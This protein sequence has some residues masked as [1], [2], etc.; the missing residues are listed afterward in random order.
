MRP[1]RLTMQAFGPY[2]GQE[3]VDFRTLGDRRFFLI[4]GPT[5]SGKTTVL[6]AICYALYGKSSGAE[7]DVREM[8]SHHSPDDLPT[9]VVFDFS[10][11]RECYRVWRRP[12]Q[13]APGRRTPLRA[14]ATL[15]QRTGIGDDV[16]DGSV[17]ATGLMRVT[18]KIEELLGFEA[19]Q[20]R[21][22]VLL[23]QGQFREALTA[24]SAKRQQ[25]LEILFGTEVYRYIELALKEKA[26]ALADALKGLK[27]RRETLLQAADAESQGELQSTFEAERARLGQ[28]RKAEKAAS[29]AADAA[30]QALSKM[31]QDTEKLNEA[32]AAAQA[33]AGL[34]S[35]APEFDVMEDKLNRARRAASCAG[36]EALLDQ[37]RREEKAKREAVEHA[38]KYLSEAESAARAASESLAAENSPERVQKRKQ[39]ETGLVTLEGLVPR[40]AEIDR[41][42][43]TAIRAGKSDAKA[44]ALATAAL[45]RKN[46]AS[47]GLA[48]ARAE[49]DEAQACGAELPLWE[50][51][52]NELNAALKRAERRARLEND[53][54]QKATAAL[55]ARQLVDEAAD[56]LE[57]A[58]RR[59]IL[60]RETWLASQAV[61]LAAA[62]EPGVPCPVCGS[63]SHPS[64]AHPAVVE[65]SGRAPSQKDLRSADAAVT[66]A[67]SEWL[68]LSEAASEAS[69]QEASV[70]GQLAELSAGDR[71]GESLHSDLRDAEKRL[72]ASTT[73][74][75]R[76]EQ[77]NETIG[78][79]EQQLTAA[80]LEAA[81]A[82][83]A[84][85]EA[86]GRLAAAGAI[87]EEK[88]SGVPVDLRSPAA[89]EAKQAK[90]RT[91]L[92]ELVR[93][94]EAAERRYQ[95]AELALAGVQARAAAA[96]EALEGAIR[97]VHARSL[98]FQ[99]KTAEAGFAS[100][101]DYH[102]SKMADDVAGGLEQAMDEFRR[103]LHAARERLARAAGEAAGIAEPDLAVAEANCAELALAAKKAMENRISLGN[104]IDQMRRQLDDLDKLA[105]KMQEVEAEHAVIARVSDVANGRGHRN[106]L[107]MTFERFVLASMLDQVTEAAT[108]RLQVMS[109][110]RYALR[111]T[112][113]RLT[114]RSAA[115]LG[116]EVFDAYTGRE[117]SVTTL[118]GGEGFMAS[119]SLALGLADVVQSYAGGIRLDTIFVDE[120]FGTLDPESLDLAIDTLVELQREGGRLVGVISHV[121]ELVE[122]IDA[123]LEISMTDR[124]SK[125]R[126]VVA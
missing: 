31:R 87:V 119:L 39:L 123:R 21:Q 117:R 115:G 67:E 94:L 55:Q 6:D 82:E 81:E 110:G 7:R 113:D 105:C 4:H 109:R 45:A 112:M 3:V 17:V 51:R 29:E 28:A 106:R 97:N 92:D 78:R 30:A 53:M 20:F 124:G 1:I 90:T 18:D 23:P 75:Q 84:G 100:A 12:E 69:Q 14:D 120:G 66:A 25:I 88:E 43:E 104:R 32:R 37:A 13:E 54:A 62:L 71:A 76:A 125:S 80:E 89:L 72:E 83:T 41:A 101:D 15:W 8:R 33:V 46:E 96:A 34:E 98:E 5:G 42:R 86:A 44:R 63:T 56:R 47:D 121:P 58:R 103:Q 77:L 9:Q 85:R 40:V 122:R 91:E 61:A 118:S 93:A 65:G 107:G 57:L 114:S 73:A 95:E 27:D 52:V 35:R 116:L 59:A 22:V 68:R 99:A 36:A 49:R 74:S 108:R 60:L 11:G 26:G 102:A 2:P 64:P 24:D 50:S 79:L 19:D 16:A 10:V 126:F 111:R 48:Q 38:Q 70:R